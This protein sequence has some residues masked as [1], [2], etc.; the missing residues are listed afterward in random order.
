MKKEELIEKYPDLVK[1]IAIE[2]C[3][4]VIL[5]GDKEEESLWEEYLAENKFEPEF[6][7]REIKFCNNKIYYLT[8]SK[9]FYELE[10]TNKINYD[11]A[12]ELIE[13]LGEITVVSYDKVWYCIGDEVSYNLKEYII[14]KFDG[15]IVIIKRKDDE[16]CIEVHISNIGKI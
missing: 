5:L 14:V 13:T 6:L 8:Y 9:K 2:F 3:H 11:L 12:I 15:E 10:G 4:K 1:K 7:V 16:N